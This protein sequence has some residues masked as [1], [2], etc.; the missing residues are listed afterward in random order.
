MDV[1]SPQEPQKKERHIL[2]KLFWTAGFLLFVVLV[3]IGAH[4]ATAYREIVVEQ[5]K[6][7]SVK[8]ILCL[9]G[10]C[11]TDKNPIKRDPNPI[12]QDDPDILNVLILGM[13][14]EDYPQDGGLLT[15]T[16]LLVIIDKTTGK[17][18]MISIPR[19]LYLDMQGTL[20]DESVINLKGK[21]NEVYVNG[22]E[23]NQG[24]TLASQMVSRITG[25]YVDRAVLFDFKAFGDIVTTLGGIDVTL[26]QPFNEKSQ[27]GY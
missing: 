23:K 27:W 11:I 5:P 17:V 25:Q 20:N 15:D 18:A 2:K 6:T 16:I 21:L 12:P 7:F 22:Y 19:D 26:A 4:F 24:L 8:N 10:T 1:I 3:Y 14:G 13:R 9:L